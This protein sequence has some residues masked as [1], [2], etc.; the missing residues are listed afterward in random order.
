MLR[1]T[2]INLQKIDTK[3]RSLLSRNL[4][5]FR[6]KKKPSAPSSPN[7]KTPIE[8][9]RLQVTDYTTKQKKEKSTKN[10]Q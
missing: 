6:Q 10:L 2:A 3:K 5:R 1:K 9:F 7:L 4:R 8:A